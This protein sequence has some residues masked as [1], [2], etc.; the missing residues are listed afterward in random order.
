MARCE[1]RHVSLHHGGTPH[2]D[3]DKGGSPSHLAG[4]SKG[5]SDPSS[6]TVRTSDTGAQKVGPRVSAEQI[7]MFAKKQPRSLVLDINTVAY[8]GE[9]FR[10]KAFA[11]NSVGK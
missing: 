7:L 5:S 6:A 2:Q 4:D 10:F 8:F 9:L 11:V 3:R 1:S